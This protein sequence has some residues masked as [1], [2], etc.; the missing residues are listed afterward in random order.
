MQCSNPWWYD[1]VLMWQFALSAYNPLVNAALESCPKHDKTAKFFLRHIGQLGG[2]DQF[3][4]LA[5]IYRLPCTAIPHIRSWCALVLPKGCIDLLPSYRWHCVYQILVDQL[6]T[7]SGRIPFL[8]LL[9]AYIMTTF[10]RLQRL[11]Y[12]GYLAYRQVEFFWE[13][14]LLG[15]FYWKNSVK[16]TASKLHRLIPCGITNIIIMYY[17]KKLNKNLYDD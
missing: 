5:L 10:T 3:T 6:A 12:G 15:A 13:I 14:W 8:P 16:P 4:V 7:L 2:A 1:M 17:K 9:T 11:Q